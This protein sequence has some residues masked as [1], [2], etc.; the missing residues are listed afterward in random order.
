VPDRMISEVTITDP[1]HP[2][3]GKRLELVSLAC[4]RGPEF[5][6]VVLADGRRR[7]VRRSVTD[8]DRPGTTGPAG[9]RISV[10]T[11]LPLARHLRCMVAASEEAPH[12]RPSPPGPL[13]PRTPGCSPSGAPAAPAAVAGADVP[14]PDPTGPAARPTAPAPSPVRGGA[15]C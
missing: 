1:H 3:H 12:A 10:R 5:V 11:L 4:A 6:V 13:P 9:P 2:L 15:P 7:L 8:L 14:G